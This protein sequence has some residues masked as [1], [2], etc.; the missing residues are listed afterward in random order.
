MSCK[1]I[2]LL[3]KAT[4]TYTNLGEYYTANASECVDIEEEV[5]QQLFESYPIE[6]TDE[7]YDNLQEIAKSLY[8][9]DDFLQ[10]LEVLLSLKKVRSNCHLQ[11]VQ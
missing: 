10:L 3:K 1:L 2:E 9:D 7:I 11:W 4:Q 8:P 6:I 5:G